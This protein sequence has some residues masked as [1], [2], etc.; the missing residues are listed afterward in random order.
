MGIAEKIESIVNKRQEKIPKIIQM[1]QRL[2]KVNEVVCALESTCQEMLEEDSETHGNIEKEHFSI[3]EQLRT[4]NTRNFHDCYDDTQELLE[5]LK[6]RFSRKQIHI[7]FVGRAGQGK[8]LLMQNISGLSGEIIPSSDGADCTGAKSIITNSGDDIVTAEI[9]FYTRKE[10]KNIIN[11]YLCEIFGKG[12][13]EIES[14]DE[15]E[16]LKQK[17]LASKVDISSAQKQS[18]YVQLKKYIEHSADVIPMLGS[19]KKVPA[20]EIESYVAQYKSADKNQ[21]YFTYLGVKVANILCSF[22]F[23]DCGKIV[24][25]DT[26]GLGDTALDIREQMLETVSHDSDVIL[27]M[28]RPDAQRPHVEQGDIDIINDI[29]EKMTADYTRRMLF[30]VI[31]KVKAD[32]CNNINGTEIVMEK[33]NQMPDFPIADHLKVDCKDKEEVERRLLVPVL[34]KLSNNLPEMDEVLLRKAEEIL[35]KLYQEYHLLAGKIGETFKASVDEDARR[36]F[37][38]EITEIIN[39]MTNSIRELYVNKPYGNRRKQICEKLKNASE[40]KLTNILKLVPAKEDVIELLNN[41]TINQHNAY[42]TLTDQTRITIINDF[43]GLNSTL[44]DLVK[45]MKRNV[46]FCLTDESQG[47]LGRLISISA[48]DEDKWLTEL[49]EY[50][51]DYPRYGLIVEALKKLSDF[52]LRMESYLIYRVRNHLDAIDVSVLPQSP[53]INSDMSKKE[54]QAS[55]II[56]WLEHNLEIVYGAIKKELEP[57]YSYPNSALW[58]VVKDFYDRIVY[59]KE[60]K[61]KVKDEWRY[62]Y[63]DSIPYIWEEEYHAYQQQKGASA[64][65]NAL[66]NKI[67]KYDDKNKFE[68]TYVEVE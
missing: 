55:D 67:H 25:V 20:E 41:G 62:L 1:Q 32:T 30:W 44:H 10:Y 57:L 40:E 8:S 5:Q 14:V 65:W 26:I 36:E 66:V 17:D 23:K 39:K 53:E 61:R 50:L 48:K 64:K 12:V 58:A 11:K 15:I 6:K 43:L 68:F 59:A 38:G 37:D 47:R 7:S 42:E 33:I 60:G 31:N 4:I 2:E 28:T 45:E 46:L 51:G 27:L 56:F 49:I 13:Y 24:L 34:E 3:L 9:T 35:Q 16:G 22:P 19:I 54:E 63:E 18:L 52:D 21:K 29:S